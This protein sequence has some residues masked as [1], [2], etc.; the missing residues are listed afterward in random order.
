[1][2]IEHH[3]I[4][5]QFTLHDVGMTSSCSHCTCIV[6]VTSSC[7]HHDVIVFMCESQLQLWHVIDGPLCMTDGPS[8]DPKLCDMS[9]PCKNIISTWVHMGLDQKT[10][11]YV[12]YILVA[13]K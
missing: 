1:M 7:L 5:V 12:M 10:Y 4:M 3:I 9:S 6:C 11:I 8:C 2:L 13:L